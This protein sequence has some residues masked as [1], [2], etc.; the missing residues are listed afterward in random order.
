MDRLD[1]DGLTVRGARPED[2]DALLELYAQLGD[3][4]GAAPAASSAAHALIGQILA[5]ESR[6]LLVAVLDER[7]LG[8]MDL[9]VV[10]N[11]THEGRPWAIV[12]NVV[13]SEAVRGRGVG[14]ALMQR[15]IELARAAGCYKVQLISGKHRTEAH[16]F[17]RSLGFGPVAEGFKLYLED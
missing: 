8:T 2:V 4:R 6:H 11:L 1:V 14:R 3:A 12:E 9:L 7:V 17:Y 16:A 15:L 10:P 13:V 5:D